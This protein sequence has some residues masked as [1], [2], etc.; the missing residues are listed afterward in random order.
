[1]ARRA[2]PSPLPSLESLCEGRQ[3]SG[4]GSRMG[5]ALEILRRVLPRFRA[6]DPI[7]F[8]TTRE[9]ARYFGIHQTAAVRIFARLEAEGLLMRVRGSGTY[10]R[11]LSAH[12]RMKPRGVVGFP[13]WQY[14]YCM[15]GDWRLFY[16]T[17][18][19][20]LRRHHFVAS[21]IFLRAE[22]HDPLV[23]TR[24]L[25]DHRL[26]ALV[27][28]KPLENTLP[29]MASV[30][31]EGVTV[32]AVMC[33][34]FPI[35]F[36]NYRL[37]DGPAILELL[38]KWRQEG[39]QRVKIFAERAYRTRIQKEIGEVALRLKLK[40]TLEEVDVTRDIY[41]VIPEKTDHLEGVI[42]SE[43]M[44]TRVMMDRSPERWISYLKKSRV[45]TLHHFDMAIQ[46]LAGWKVDMIHPHWGQ[47]AELVARDLTLGKYPKEGNRVDI[48][49]SLQRDVPA[50]DIAIRL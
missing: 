11:S 31:D 41:P 38:R 44:V 2:I 22:D 19:D 24:K 34:R 26:D 23:M 30:A 42:L 48:I 36:V 3:R 45:L 50:R 33:H 37:D 5:Q 14:A 6:K 35:P 39:C 32:R 20:T 12:P 4:S 40:V 10:L 16:D 9:V 13:V 1:M 27:W 7:P 15:L 18:E 47:L 25:L 17:M 46:E 8:H 43:S 28:F 49:S 29:V 21:L